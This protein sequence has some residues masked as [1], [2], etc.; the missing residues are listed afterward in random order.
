M[1]FI[2]HVCL[3]LHLNYVSY[4][5]T[6]NKSQG[7]LCVQLDYTYQNQCYSQLYVV[8][9]RVQSIL[10]LKIL[11]HDNDNKSLSSTTNVVFKEVF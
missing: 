10:G 3:S 7:Q 9:S 1:K 11:I 8:V 6:I 2:F 5:I 4:V